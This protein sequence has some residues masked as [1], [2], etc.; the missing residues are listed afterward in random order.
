MFFV[1]FVLVRGISFV[2][3]S[4]VCG[5][6]SNTASASKPPQGVKKR[7]LDGLDGRLT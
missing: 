6:S 4:F 7:Q 2:C 3:G 5:G 1:V